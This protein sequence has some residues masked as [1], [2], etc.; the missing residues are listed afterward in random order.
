MTFPQQQ[1]PGMPPPAVTTQSPGK[2]APLIPHWLTVCLAGGLLFAYMS[3]NNFT[4]GEAVGLAIVLGFGALVVLMIRALVRIGD[5]RPDPVVVNTFA[6]HPPAGW[7]VD[8]QGVT[9]WFDGEK[10]CE[11][12]QPPIG[13]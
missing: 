10:W 13:Q 5:K 7:Y 12:V 1:P 4:S 3:A 9:R 6:A 8:P 11:Q 2:P